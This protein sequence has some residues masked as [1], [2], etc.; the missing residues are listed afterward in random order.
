MAHPKPSSKDAEKEIVTSGSDAHEEQEVFVEAP[1]HDIKYRTLSWQFVAV[2]MIAEIVSNGMLSL[3]SALAVVG[4]PPKHRSSS[5]PHRISRDFCVHNMGD[6]GYILGGPLIRELL[7]G[8][9]I[10]FAIFGTGSEILSGQ[11]ALSTLSNNALCTV[12]FVLIFSGATFLLSLPRTLGNLS[13]TGIFSVALIFIAVIVAMIGAGI[14]PAPDRVIQATASS[15]F[16]Q[17]FLAI[18]NPVFAYAG[19]FM[20]FILISEMR[21]PEDAMKAAWCLQ[22]FATVLYAMFS[23]VMYVFIGNTVQSPAF[24]SL[25]P[26]WAKIAFG[27]AMGNFLIAGALYSH[28]AAKLVFVRF[29]RD[30]V[31]MYKHTVLG[32]LLWTV[33]CFVAVA[34]AFILAVA[35]PIFSY[36]IGIAASLFAAW[37]TYGLAGFFWLHDAYHLRGGVEGLRRHP[38]QTTL[39]VLT[40]LAGA[41]IC[42]AGTDRE[43]TVTPPP[44]AI[45]IS[46]RPPTS[47]KQKVKALAFFVVFNIAC[48]MINGAQFVFLLPLKL[49]PF[50]WSQ[51]LYTEGI[52]Y[53][54]GA[55]GCLLILMCQLF[56]PTKLV[57][58]FETKGKGAFKESEIAD[59]VVKNDK[60]EVASLNLPEKFVLIANHQVYVDWWYAWCFLYYIGKGVHEH[61]YITLKKSLR[62]VP[63]VGWGMQF[64]N[65]IFLARSWASDRVELARHLSALGKAA[66]NEDHPLAFILYP[67][68]TLVS[69]DTRPISRKFADK[70]GI[71]DMTNI[72][73]P[74]ST[75]LLY[76]LRSLAPRVKDLRLIDIT[77]VYP[78]IPPL[79]Y[80]QSYYTLR[81]IFF[82][83]VPP[84][85]IHMHLRMFDIHSDVPI[86]DLSATNP[87]TIPEPEKSGKTRTVEVEIPEEERERFDS[88]LRALWT[89]KDE[90]ISMFLDTG[91]YST[92]SPL[93]I[94][95][96]IRLRR[97]KEILD[98]FTFFLPVVLAYAVRK[99]FH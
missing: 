83:G 62:W 88:W 1:E 98:C 87:S 27:T 46:H 63:I 4:K 50:A 37:Y 67:E 80:G 25:P 79:G 69:K 58:T 61:V 74:R 93:P 26:T 86:G 99:L 78:G 94:D 82:D 65:F 52:R 60:G 18:T 72:L 20:F 15:N 9:T 12:Y 75:G 97:R 8:G 24:Q 42:I 95:I 22:V 47:W 7:A 96:P 84:P 3:P 11:Q 6:A 34:I 81:S 76:S 30:T 91:K 89:E 44:F 48:L 36:L 28:T 68:G 10:I 2:L 70:M 14:N 32:W 90:S 38:I 73:L 33:L 16:Y 53:T 92:A 35:V 40:I 45:P 56:A 39:S 59:I 71:S 17:A 55:F 31:H 77:T 43:M 29:F 66:E 85:A 49:L 21:R 54:K 13:W 64:F 51:K 57:V 41:F 23:V 19:H 5:N